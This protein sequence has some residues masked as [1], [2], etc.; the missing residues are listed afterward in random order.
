MQQRGHEIAH[1]VVDGDGLIGDADRIDAERQ[2][3]GDLL[4][5]L[6]DVPTERQNIAAFAHRDSEADRRLPADPEQGLRR[7][8]VGSYHLG[9]VAQSECAPTDGEGDGK[10]ILLRA[11]GARDA[12]RKRFVSGLQDAGRSHDVLRLQGCHQGCAIDAEPGERLR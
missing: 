9:Y 3:L 8:R 4:H 5:G 1:R 7:I 12:Q 2:I 11:E 6:R 10:H